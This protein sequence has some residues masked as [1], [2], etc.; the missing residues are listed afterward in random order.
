ME[1]NFIQDWKYFRFV[2]KEVSINEK[3]KYGHFKG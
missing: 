1:N 2:N 3:F